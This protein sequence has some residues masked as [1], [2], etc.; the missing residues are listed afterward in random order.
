M[1]LFLFVGGGVAFLICY[2][3]GENFMS[4]KPL[5]VEICLLLVVVDKRT[6]RRHT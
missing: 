5:V 4:T 3:G 6:E 2:G 1:G